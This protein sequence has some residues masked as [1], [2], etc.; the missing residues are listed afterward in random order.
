MK[1]KH[2]RSRKSAAISNSR[3]AAYA[4]AGAASA[5]AAVNTAEADI[6]Y[7]NPPDEII[8]GTFGAG[9][10]DLAYFPLF[11]PGP[12]GR[13]FGLIHIMA[14]S[15]SAEGVARFLNPTGQAS[16]AFAGFLAGGYNYVSKLASGNNVSAFA[17]NAATYGTLA[18]RGGYGNDQWLDPGIGFVGFR[19]D[20]GSGR[21]VWLGPD[22]YERRAIE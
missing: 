4:T 2:A 10:Y 20:S 18:F 7:F 19:F 12:A 11:P 17:F 13:S 22:R 8:Q 6:N 15:G 3:W 9:N 1:T 5:L 21:P 16:A 14:T